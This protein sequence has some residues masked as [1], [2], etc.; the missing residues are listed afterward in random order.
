LK[1][2]QTEAD[3]GMPA[4]DQIEVTISPPDKLSDADWSRVEAILRA[5]GAVNVSSAL[6]EIPIS[7]VLVLARQTGIVVGFGA[8]KRERPDYA[9]KTQDKAGGA[10]DLE[11]CELGYV[12][13]DGDFQ[14]QGISSRILD[15]LLAAYPHGLFCTTDSEEMKGSLERRD[16]KQTGK[17]WRG[18][19]GD[20]SLWIRTLDTPG[21]TE[22]KPAD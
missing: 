16:F 19:R 1:G 6:A 5:G 7:T 4:S 3:F 15:T 11:M 17:T 2:R 13:I 9:R 8:I 18:N 14:K 12:A 21:K 10:F 20:L 22:T